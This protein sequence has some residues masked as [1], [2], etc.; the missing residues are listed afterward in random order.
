MQP[1]ARAVLV[2]DDL[3]PADALV[4][5][6]GNPVFPKVMAELVDD[7]VVDERQQPVAFVD[8][9]HPNAE[10]GKDAG[11]FAADHAGA[12]DRQCPR[13]P[14]EL[15]HV[16]TGENPLSIERDMRVAGGFRPGGDD[17]LLCLD[18]AGGG[19]VDVVEADGVRRDKGCRRRDQLDI[20]APQLVAGDVDLVLDHPVGA[21]QQILHRDVLFDGI[22]GAV[23][24][25]RTIAAKFERRLAQGLGRDR[26][27]IDAAPAEH[28]PSFDDR[29][30]LVELGALDRR[31]LP[32]RPGTDHQKIIVER[33][34]SHALAPAAE[35]SLRLNN[36]ITLQQRR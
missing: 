8:Q 9:G 19:A 11:I 18:R 2:L 27:E 6:Q 20:I 17:D 23:K 21:K 22:G 28:G 34:P 33:V 16:V 30:F 35:P 3:Q 12:D 31:A 7:F 4:E 24:F 14:I 36:A 13:Q 1:D 5:P 10:S 32:G 29:D 26:A 25:P 15:Q